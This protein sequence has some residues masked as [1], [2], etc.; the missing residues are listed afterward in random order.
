MLSL[1]LLEKMLERYCKLNIC[2]H[3]RFPL[4]LLLDDV[5]VI[6]SFINV[7]VK[8]SCFHFKSLIRQI[9]KNTK[10]IGLFRNGIINH[11]SKSKTFEPPWQL[12][13]ADEA[14][15]SIV[16]KNNGITILRSPPFYLMFIQS[17][18]LKI[19]D[20][21]ID[22]KC[23]CSAGYLYSWKILTFSKGDFLISWILTMIELLLDQNAFFLK[24]FGSQGY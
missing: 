2:C 20:Q 18:L 21:S 14:C 16:F 24:Q 19:H 12:S 11:F 10:V 23:I 4:F 5:F 17:S 15:T 13:F 22:I 8:N 9:Y 3:L 1:A 6:L 7:F